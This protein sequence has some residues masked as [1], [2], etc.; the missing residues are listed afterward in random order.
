MAV[1]VCGL[2]VKFSTEDPSTSGL[3][4]S[5]TT[6]GFMSF[7]WT[8]PSLITRLFAA[9]VAMSWAVIR[10]AA[11]AVPPMTST[12]AIPI[13]AT[14]SNRELRSFI[15]WVLFLFSPGLFQRTRLGESVVS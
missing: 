13:P 15:R 11:V 4:S 9:P 8:D 12:V 6:F 7:W 14:V 5:P 10:L 1:I 2:V 3:W